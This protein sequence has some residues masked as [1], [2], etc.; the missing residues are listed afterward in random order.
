M[1]LVDCCL[2]LFGGG[3]LVLFDCVDGLDGGVFRFGVWLVCLFD[4]NL[5]ADGF[6]V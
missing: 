5:D 4:C 1:M 2:L 3:S 6:W